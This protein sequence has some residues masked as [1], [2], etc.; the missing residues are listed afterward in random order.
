MGLIK[1]TFVS[2]ILFVVL[3]TSLDLFATDP[4][5]SQSNKVEDVASKDARVIIAH[6]Y[7]RAVSDNELKKATSMMTIDVANPRMI[8]MLRSILK[9]EN[10]DVNKSLYKLLEEKPSLAV[11]TMD[12]DTSPAYFK[13]HLLK[14][15]GSWKIQGESIGVY[16]REKP[17]K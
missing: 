12:L 14:I 7:F 2:S 5:S 13:V 6:N 1:T 17:K 4:T 9:S 15:D 16:L 11:V 8:D 3:F 10:V